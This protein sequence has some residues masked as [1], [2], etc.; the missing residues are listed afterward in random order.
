M[1]ANQPK[2]AKLEP[3]GVINDMVFADR[4]VTGSEATL[5][6]ILNELRGMNENLKD[7][8]RTVD[9]LSI[10]IQGVIDAIQDSKKKRPRKR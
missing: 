8:T 1:K 10:Y 4:S 9:S 3:R 6:A 7:L 5:G 2:K